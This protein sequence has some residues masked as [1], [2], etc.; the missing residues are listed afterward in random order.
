MDFADDSLLAKCFLHLLPLQDCESNPTKYQ[1]ILD[2]QS[3]RNNF[4]TYKA[5]STDYIA[6]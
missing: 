3:E 6:K 4:P 2:N 5:P 1:W